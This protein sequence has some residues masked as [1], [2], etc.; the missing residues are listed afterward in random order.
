MIDYVSFDK[1]LLETG[2]KKLPV[3]VTV[4]LYLAYGASLIKEPSTIRRFAETG[5]FLQEW[6]DPVLTTDTDSSGMHKVS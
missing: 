6:E 5:L 4:L 2:L 1:E 3:T